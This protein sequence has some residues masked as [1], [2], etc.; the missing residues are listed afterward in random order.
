MKGSL[1][2][3]VVLVSL[4]GTAF[5]GA[6]LAAM[7]PSES[8]GIE[9]DYLTDITGLFDSDN[10]PIYSDYNPASNW[11]GYRSGNADYTSGISYKTLTR[12]NGIPVIQE[13][14]MEDHQITLSS[15]GLSNE[16]PPDS[17]SGYKSWYIEYGGVKVDNP[18]IASVKRIYDAIEPQLT[19]PDADYIRFD[20]SGVWG[21]YNYGWGF[22]TSSVAI[23]SYTRASAAYMDYTPANDLCKVYNS[24]GT[25]LYAG[26][27]ERLSAAIAWGGTGDS[28]S[29]AITVYEITETT[30]V[31]MDI[32]EGVKQTNSTIT[33]SN[34]QTM[35]G[36]DILVRP[37]SDDITFQVKTHNAEGTSIGSVEVT[38]WK[39]SDGTHVTIELL[40]TGG[41]VLQ[42]KNTNLGNWDTILIS[43]DGDS[44]LV[45]ISGVMSFN[46]FMDY[47]VTE[48]TV[49]MNVWKG[50]YL[51][52]GSGTIR[53]LGTPQT[54]KFGIVNTSVFLNNYSIAFTNPSLDI[55][56]Y[57]P[58]D[59]RYKLTFDSFALYGDSVTINGTT[60][61]MDGNKI[62]A[63][64]TVD[65]A[66]GTGLVPITG[67]EVATS[68]SDTTIIWS[69][70]R[71]LTEATEDY[72][73]SFDGLWYFN[74]DYYTGKNVTIT[75][76][77]WTPYSWG[78]TKAEATVIFLGMAALGGFVCS[79][80]KTMG[81]IDWTIILVSLIAGW[82]ML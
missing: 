18:S 26:T 62:N 12:Y 67:L 77:E 44:G 30:P 7:T 76:Y 19:E 56:D 63:T 82:V 6:T 48:R 36:I 47:E 41:V 43:F 17:A 75:E 4:I 1:G 58:G 72:T 20:C 60:Y 70:G 13:D 9:Y 21:C 34:G 35:N 16:I 65:G 73:I 54:T 45:T 37:T 69:N 49:S 57:Y 81:W 51:D 32:R 38:T 79:R 31:Y 55:R 5:F 52:S 68:G 50:T 27:G 22:P 42:K 24:S 80:L 71:T 3:V 14:G 39:Y 15:L 64:W 59:D 33:W 10:I 25:M 40:S 23:Q 46:S 11:N 53:I 8:E 78:L 28:L 2:L 61:Q 74:S 29:T 66:T